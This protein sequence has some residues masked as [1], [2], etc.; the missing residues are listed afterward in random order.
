MT[1]KWQ[2]LHFQ[3]DDGLVH[4]IT[5]VSDD[6]GNAIWNFIFHDGLDAGYV[7]I[8]WWYRVFIIHSSY[9]NHSLHVVISQ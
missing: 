8:F 7:T 1:L 2:T 4:H 5:D 9:A 3:F 6:V